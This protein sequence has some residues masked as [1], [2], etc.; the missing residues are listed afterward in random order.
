MKRYRVILSILFVVCGAGYLWIEHKEEKAL[1]QALARQ[2]RNVVHLSMAYNH[3]LL[4]PLS[5][6]LITTDPDY[7]KQQ[8]T[9]LSRASVIARQWQ[10]AGITD[11]S[12]SWVYAQTDHLAARLSLKPLDTY[13]TNEVGALPP[14]QVEPP[15]PLGYQVPDQPFRGELLTEKQQVQRAKDFVR[16][17][18]GEEVD[19]ERSGGSSGP[20]GVLYH[21]TPWIRGTRQGIAINVDV[22][23]RGGHIVRYSRDHNPGAQGAPITLEAAEQAAV[24]YLRRW[25]PEQSMRRSNAWESEGEAHFIF[26]SEWDGAVVEAEKVHLS[27]S[28]TYGF[29]SKLDAS[30]WYAERDPDRLHW[31]AQLTAEEAKARIQVPVAGGELVVVRSR[32]GPEVLAYRFSTEDK[33]PLHIYI[34]AVTGAEELIRPRE[35][36]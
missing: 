13:W 27:V 17:D 25:N 19:W 12:P 34:N 1:V 11:Y 24:N 15:P 36:L 7:K 33:R 8:L 28:L 31:K 6:L 23:E 22:T 21:Y 14:L 9:E 35:S 2:H 4:M 20:S 10:L 32:R 5:A 3:N 29:L 16:S 18:I 26:L 30:K